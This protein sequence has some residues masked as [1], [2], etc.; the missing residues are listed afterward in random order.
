MAGKNRAGG[1]RPYRRARRPHGG[2]DAGIRQDLRHAAPCRRTSPPN[3]EFECNWLHS[4]PPVSG[5]GRG[6][7]IVCVD[8]A[9]WASLISSALAS[10]GPGLFGVTGKARAIITLTKQMVDFVHRG[11]LSMPEF[12]VTRVFETKFP[13]AH[14]PHSEM[15]QIDFSTEAETFSFLLSRSDFERLGRKIARLLAETPP[16][17]QPR[18]AKL[19]TRV[20]SN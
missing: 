19:P 6:S 8:S 7:D 9:L 20:E 14:L 4:L 2:P 13:I 1:H 15:G 5:A 10:A 3:L 12:K 17:S 18:V 16:P 11:A